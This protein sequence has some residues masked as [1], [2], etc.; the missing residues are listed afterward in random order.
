MG[1]VVGIT[2]RAPA[3]RAE[4]VAAAIDDAYAAIEAGEAE[5]SEW[6]PDSMV[7]RMMRGET[8]Q[9]SP[10]AAG[11]LRHAEVLRAATNG[12][13]D[14]FW[15]GGEASEGPHGWT[16]RGTID[17]G[18]LA[19]GFLVDLAVASLRAA[20]LRNFAVDAAGDLYLAGRQHPGGWG[21]SVD[22]ADAG[23]APRVSDAAVST[24]SQDQQPGHLRDARTGEAVG[25]VRVTT[26][27]ARTALVA[28]A[29]DTAMF[30]TC[31][32]IAPSALAG[33]AVFWVTAAGRRHEII[34]DGAPEFR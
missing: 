27:F 1:T 14:V 23:L 29:M 15:R 7:S 32:E 11:M 2:V 5:I 21:W 6:R 34:G 10:A 17:L 22:I 33:T 16:G 19:K 13:Y 9:L 18:S 20:G 28:D 25:C 31:G 4:A 12:R 3:G 24:A 30:V 8:V 26:V